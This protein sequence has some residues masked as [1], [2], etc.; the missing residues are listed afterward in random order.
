MPEPKPND[1]L[2]LLEALTASDLDFVI[3][4]GA[5]AILHGAATATY[6]L[7]ILAPF[8]LS[9]CERLLKA[10]GPLHPRLSHTPDK[11]PLSFSAQEL[12][13]FKNLYLMTDLG[14]LDVLGSLPPVGVF[15]DVAPTSQLVDVGGVTVR[16]VSLPMLIQ[17]KAAMGRP[18]DKQVEAE[19]RAI[20][21][22]GN[23]PGI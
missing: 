8:N 17:V 16:V 2:R 21:A 22:H 12:S 7:D 9:S 6:D 14:R 20:A 15:E 23:K 10:I 18:K 11:R 4:G 1:F 5:A 3:V 19:L 13:S